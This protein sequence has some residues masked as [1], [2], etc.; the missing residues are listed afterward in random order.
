[1]SIDMKQILVTGGAGFIG[2]NLILKLLQMGYHITILDNL[3]AQVHGQAAKLNPAL[4]PY[5]SFIKGDIKDYH[6][7]EKALKNQNIIIHLAADTATGQSMYEITKC[8]KSNIIGT[9]NLLQCLSNQHMQLEKFI[10]A[11]SRAV[12]G[13]G[14]YICPRCGIVY[15]KG[16]NIKDLKQRRYE[17]Y[18]PSCHGHIEKMPSDEESIL[19]P[20]SIYGI[21]KLTQEQY[22]RVICGALEIPYTILRFQNVYGEGQSLINPYT[23]ILSIFSSRILT[24]K[25]IHIFEDGLESRDFIHVQDVVSVILSVLEQDVSEVVLNV[26]SGRS[27]SLI[28]LV[29]LLYRFY[30]MPVNYKINYK[31]RLGDI[32]HNCADINLIHEVLGFTPSISLEEGLLRFT[33][34]AR[35]MNI[36][37]DYYEESLNVMKGKGI[38]KS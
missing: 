3:E 4:K 37:E 29:K 9:A 1:M 33:A 34:W 21:T 31:Y 13:E 20:Q 6:A 12:Y 23:G 16:R 7:C 8:T 38:L 32:R 11:S 36:F 26:G 10:F 25:P 22:I 5:V 24:G 30:D 28:E 17:L 19:M 18:C 35:K 27:T 15:P 2:T 14:K